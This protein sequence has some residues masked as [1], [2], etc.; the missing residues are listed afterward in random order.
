MA[1]RVP[2]PSVSEPDPE[3]ESEPISPTT[4]TTTGSTVESTPAAP[5]VMPPPFDMIEG[6]CFAD[7]RYVDRSGQPPANARIF[8]R[9][10]TKE[11][12]LLQSSLPE[13]GIWVR[14]SDT[15]MDLLRAVLL[16]PQDTPYADVPLFF[17][18]FLPPDYPTSPPAVSFFS[19]G[20]CHG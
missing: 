19:Y 12:G 7:H 2:A 14:A 8:G 13:R 16:G 17:D 11:W 10:V 18:I 15:H 6:E 1:A 9:T 5:V 4:T 3:P 20:A